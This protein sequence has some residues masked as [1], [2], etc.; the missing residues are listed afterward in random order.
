MDLTIEQ[1]KDIYRA[2]IRRGHDEATAFD[3]GSI[4]HYPWITE[5][6][7]AMYDILNEGKS[8]GDVDH[9]SYDTVKEMLR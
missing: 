6:E 1:I 8:L 3:C 9:I 2:G 4:T 7:E 5:L